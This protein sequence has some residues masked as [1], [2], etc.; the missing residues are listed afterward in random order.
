MIANKLQIPSGD[1]FRI[2]R[3]F[4]RRTGGDNAPAL[5]SAAGTHVDYIVRIANYIQIMLDDNN[6]CTAF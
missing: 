3:N 2:L 5:L 1:A 6:G 4:L